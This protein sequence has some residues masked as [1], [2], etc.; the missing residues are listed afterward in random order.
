MV[1]HMNQ[2]RKILLIVVQ[3]QCVL[4][5]SNKTEHETVILLG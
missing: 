3:V 2:N 1:N 5:D 4:E